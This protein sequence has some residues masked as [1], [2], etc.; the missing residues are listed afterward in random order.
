MGLRRAD[1]AHPTPGPP[2]R[3]P[4]L[5]AR[6]PCSRPCDWRVRAHRPAPRTPHVP[7]ARRPRRDQS[8][9]RCG[10]VRALT[11]GV[12]GPRPP[13][14]T[15]AQDGR[16]PDPALGPHPT[17]GTKAPI[18]PRTPHPTPGIQ[19][20]ALPRN[21]HPTPGTK[22]LALPRTPRPTPGTQTS[23]LPRTPTHTWYQGPGLA[24]DP[25]PHTRDP[26][27]GLAPKLSPHTWYQGPG[28]APDP[29]PHTRD[30][31]LGPA[32][33]S[34]PHPGSWSRPC[35]EPP[36]PHPGTKAPAPRFPEALNSEGQC[37]VG[38]ASERVTCSGRQL[39][40]LSIL[41]KVSFLL[42]LLHVV[43]PVVTAHGLCFSSIAFGL[44]Y[45]P[46]LTVPT[47]ISLKSLL[48][49]LQCSLH[50]LPAACS[51]GS[52]PR[53]ACGKKA[54]HRLVP[55]CLQRFLT[56]RPRPQRPTFQLVSENILSSGFL[57]LLSPGWS[58][59]TQSRLTATCAYQRRS[60]TV[61][62]RLVSNSQPQVIHPPRLPKVLGLQAGVHWYDLG[63]L[64]PLLLGFKRFS[65]LSLPSSWNYRRTPPHLATFCIFSRDGFFM[66][67]RLLLNSW[68]Q[69]TPLPRPPKVDYRSEPLRLVWDL[70]RKYTQS[71]AP[72]PRLECRGVISV[73]CN[74]HLP[75]SR[76]ST[77]LSLLSSWDYSAGIT[78]VS[79][80]TQ[81]IFVFLVEKGF[82]HVSQARLEL[83]AL[84]DQ[85]TSASQS[86]G[87]TDSTCP[88]A[89]CVGGGRAGLGGWGCGDRGAYP[90]E[91]PVSELGRLLGVRSLRTI[92]ATRRNLVSTKNTKISQAWWCAPVSPAT[93][94]AEAGE[95]LEPRRRRLQ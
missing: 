69:V 77:C 47:H 75:G 9:W 59:V 72:S 18:L 15:A 80:C 62:V 46:S 94:E 11:S 1:W 41:P 74:L 78:G 49:I 43:L 65:C 25:P 83:L 45:S 56:R 54:L 44:C 93:F 76:G 30:P 70:N 24:P 91:A 82:C 33:N 50:Q 42:P 27:L 57:S 22:A 31:D 21:S 86:A 17:P 34:H 95:S 79:H 16:G 26:D 10:A 35:P 48:T 4:G 7:P 32:L 73:Y 71:I 84:S 68:P 19:T 58:A 2:L 38:H 37:G 64:Q 6:T 55:A 8:A 63:S 61:V 13:P 60:F 90:E 40:I 87:I 89:G 20:S 85:P 28:L 67:S 12:L 53:S 23:A 52:S 88:E 81:L 66:L 36:T 5:S 3:L 29:P 92:W 14:L 39:Q 51:R